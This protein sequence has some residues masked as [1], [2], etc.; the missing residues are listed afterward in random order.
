MRIYPLAL[1]HADTRQSATS[2]SN[3]T[4]TARM[5]ER[6]FKA[7]IKIDLTPIC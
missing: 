7:T 6:G 3:V 5:S 2:V 1:G 4:C